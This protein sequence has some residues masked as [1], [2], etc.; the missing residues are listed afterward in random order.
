M[1]L[2]VSHVS[3]NRLRKRE[4]AC[5]L[6]LNCGFYGEDAITCGAMHMAC[7]TDSYIHERSMGVRK[8]RCMKEQQSVPPFLCQKTYHA[9]CTQAKLKGVDCMSV[10][11][12][13]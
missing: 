13:P 6:L 9:P 2:R 7:V 8:A 11:H 3:L 4:T 12:W 1:M 10:T 5:R